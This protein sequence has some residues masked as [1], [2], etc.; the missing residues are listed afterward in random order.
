MSTHAS[1][2]TLLPGPLQKTERGGQ[3]DRQTRQTRQTQQ[4]RH[5]RTWDPWRL[6]FVLT[7]ISLLQLSLLVLHAM[8]LWSTPSLLVTCS[9]DKMLDG[10]DFEGKVRFCHSW[11]GQ[12][13][14]RPGKHGSGWLVLCIHSQEADE[15]EHP[16]S[17][18]FL[19]PPP[20]FSVSMGL[21]S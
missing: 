21:N 20:P 4:T 5:A 14:W 10:T 3:T 12:R 13:M 8:I 6:F 15:E 9:Y 7:Q 2:E 1:I 11:K 16:G 19:L 18:G 17:T